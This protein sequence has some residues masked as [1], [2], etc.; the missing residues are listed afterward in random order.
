[1]DIVSVILHD[2]RSKLSVVCTS[3]WTWV[4]DKINWTEYALLLWLNLPPLCWLSLI[5]PRSSGKCEKYWENRDRLENGPVAIVMLKTKHAVFPLSQRSPHTTFPRIS[6][7]GPVPERPISAN[8]GLIFCST[9]CIYL[10]MHC[11]VN[12]YC[13]SE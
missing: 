2:L 11:C 1:M 5:C 8:P 4:S 9:F 3:E 7:Q 13:V 10:P 12:R 6:I